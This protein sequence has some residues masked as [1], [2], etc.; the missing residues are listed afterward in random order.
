MAYDPK[1]P[2]DKA[3]LDK[4]V[5]DAL[6]EQAAEHE[7]DIAGLKTKNKELLTKLKAAN[8]GKDGDPAEVA[9]LEGELEK[10][11]KDLKAVTKERD[12]NA[13]LLDTVNKD[14]ETER[15]FSSKTLTENALT[16]ALLEAKVAP[17]FMPAVKAMLSGKATIKTEGENR[18]VVVGD[19]SL[20]DFV[21]E[22][23]QGDEGK[24]YIA[25]G[26]NGGGG[27]GNGGGQGPSGNKPTMTRV[28]YE[29]ADAGTRSAHFAAG[30]TL[31][32]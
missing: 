5:K 19:K 28:A 20:G 31:S 7:S 25:A 9:R 6:E 26:N 3:I 13:K 4:A 14:L 22:W 17:Q 18:S 23:S 10:V 30:G 8:E 27:A 12:S 2:A 32:D 1:D 11:Q 15:G 21:K 29:A 24:H 16:S